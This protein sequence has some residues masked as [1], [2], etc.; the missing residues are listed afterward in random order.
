MST[1]LVAAIIVP[2][3]I[4]AIVVAINVVLR[5]KG[6]NIPGRTVVRRSKGH[7][8][9]TTWVEGGSLKAERLGPLTRYQRCPAGKAR[10]AKPGQQSPASGARPA[11]PGRQSPAGK[12]RPGGIVTCAR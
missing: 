3:V 1:G 6:Y 10:P 9:R 7:L 4:A 2:V 5:R 11:K 12:A 8:F